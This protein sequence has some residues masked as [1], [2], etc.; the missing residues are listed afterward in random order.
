MEI[1]RQWGIEADIEAAGLPRAASEYFF[2]GDTLLA[3]DFQRFDRADL[4]RS[5]SAS[6]TE[7]LICAQ[8]LVEAVLLRTA[9]DAGVRVDFSTELVGLVD[10][11][12]GVRATFADGTQTEAA[13]VVAAD[14]ARSTVR[15]LL[16]IDV[17]GPGAIGDSVS[18]L[19]EAEL[20]DRVADRLS[21]IY[22]VA[23]P[24]PSAL[25]AVVDNDRRW[26]LMMA[27]DP[28]T[29]PDELFT[30]EHC[31]ER[32]RAALGDDDVV[33]DFKHRWFFQP[34]AYVADRFKVGHVFLAGDAAHLTTPFGALGMNCGIADAHNLAW[35][36]A[37]VLDGWGGDSL[38]Q[39]YE[40]E[41]R[42]VAQITSE[43]SILREDISSGP[44]RS[45]FDGVTLGYAYRSAAIVDDGT[46]LPAVDDAVHDYVPTARPG[47]RA[48]HVWLED[49]RSTLDLF[50]SDFVVMSDVDVPPRDHVERVIVD[51][52]QWRGTYGVERG[53]VV[54]VRPDGHVAWRSRERPSDGELDRAVAIATGHAEP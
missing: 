44:P 51:D 43:A 47:S 32:V 12:G 3:T 10:G 46:P 35:K 20:A 45:A 48:P 40:D 53:G 38:L 37:A 14:G 18:I 16:G 31:I 2:V 22:K 5:A 41:R 36:L 17:T 24:H 19:V 4:G 39:T 25:F 49:G 54:L 34:T 13:F 27:R 33:L 15:S 6:P 9:L 8:D 30:D 42:P 29:E 26:L 21:I 28:A 11:D 50:G 1:F 23:H 52:D 7:R